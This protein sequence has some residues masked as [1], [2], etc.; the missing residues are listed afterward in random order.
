[1]G[2]GLKTARAPET[3]P[4][5]NPPRVLPRPEDAM[6]HA[7]AI[8]MVGTNYPYT[9]YLPETARAVQIELDA[10][11]VGNRLP[12]DVP[13]VGTARDIL[14]EMRPLLRRKDDGSFLSKLRND[15]R[16]WRED[17]TALE[18][19]D[20]DPIQ[21]QYLIRMIDRVAADDAIL[22]TDSGTAATWAARHF[23]IRGDR[24]FMLSG[25]LATMA[26]DLP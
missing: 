9:R 12:V 24:K 10:T 22:C 15:M 1:M 20:R 23:E 4:T 3:A 7:D 25:N 13:L 5:Y 17:M 19:P 6:E 16:E 18:D 14:E 21:P 26:P 2:G 8:L 11:R